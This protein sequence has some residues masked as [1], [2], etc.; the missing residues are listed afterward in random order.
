[1]LKRKGAGPAIQTR[2]GGL[3][4]RDEKRLVAKGSTW[5]K[6]STEKSQEY[7]VIVKGHAKGG[8]V[9]PQHEEHVRGSTEVL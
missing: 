4:S 6:R 3:R 5:K 8:Q 2:S 7:Y 1:M 9:H